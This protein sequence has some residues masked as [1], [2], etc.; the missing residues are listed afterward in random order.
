M[1]NDFDYGAFV[2]YR[3]TATMSDSIWYFRTN[4]IKIVPAASDGS[5]FYHCI[6][7]GL[8]RRY[9]NDKEVQEM[10]KH[11][12]QTVEDKNNSDLIEVLTKFQYITNIDEYKKKVKRKSTWGGMT[13]AYLL[14]IFYGIRIVLIEYSSEGN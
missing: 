8:N 2:D 1:D 5:C 4:G 12:I 10:R 11:V 13:E 14:T 6:F 7:Y 3:S 9:P